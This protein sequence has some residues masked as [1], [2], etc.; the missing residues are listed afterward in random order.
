MQM[1]AIVTMIMPKRERRFNKQIFLTNSIDYL[2]KEIARKLVLFLKRSDRSIKARIIQNSGV[3]IYYDEETFGRIQNGQIVIPDIEEIKNL[4][5]EKKPP[6]KKSIK[7]EK[8]A[9]TA[10]SASLKNISNTSEIQNTSESKQQEATIGEISFPN[11]LLSRMSK[12][13]RSL[14]KIG[15]LEIER[16]P[17]KKLENYIDILHAEKVKYDSSFEKEREIINYINK[18]TQIMSKRLTEYLEEE[19][20]VF[21]DN[22]IL[23][24]LKNGKFNK[25]L[26]KSRDESEITNLIFKSLRNKIRKFP[27]SENV[28]IKRIKNILQENK[29]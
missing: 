17:K 15:L 4:K 28:L 8:S 26:K 25:F 22:Y 9:A 11:Y 5:I 13:G 10:K 2:D 1:Q 16:T 23:I 20:E 24:P 6:K 27:L 18:L 21:L 14:I 3:F 12:D 19:A 7:R 29:I